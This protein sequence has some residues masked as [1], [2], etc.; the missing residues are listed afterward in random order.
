MRL[1]S[2][3]QSTNGAIWKYNWHATVSPDNLAPDLRKQILTDLKQF[4]ITTTKTI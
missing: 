2:N 3:L 4:I 1:V